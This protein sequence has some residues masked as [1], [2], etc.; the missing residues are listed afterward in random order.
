MSTLLQICFVI[1]TIAVAA[2][3][4]STIRAVQHFRRTSEEFAKLAIDARQWL[5]QV[6]GVTQSAG[7]IV[8]T[9][10]DVAP[11]VRRVVERIEEI[12]ERTVGISDAVLH[13]VELP[14]RQ[15]VAMARGV[16]YGAQRFMELIGQRFSGRSATNGGNY[17]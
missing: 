15:A 16:R 8:G 11:R 2:I 6:Q 4:V 14:V 10:R 13:E 5:Q 12:G 9:F 17:E 3:A 7:E 1:V